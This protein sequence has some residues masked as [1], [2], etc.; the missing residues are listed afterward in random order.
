MEGRKRVNKLIHSKIY[1]L[2]LIFKYYDSFYKILCS[3]T[4]SCI[5]KMFG[6]SPRQTKESTRT[7]QAVSLNFYGLEEWTVVE[8]RIMKHINFLF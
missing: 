3:Y 1:R 6:S 8:N 2:Y 7:K 5:H 4:P